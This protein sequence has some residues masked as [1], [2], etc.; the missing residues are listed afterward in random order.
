MEIMIYIF[1]LVAAALGFEAGRVAWA[2]RSAMRRVEARRR[3]RELAGRLESAESA[4]E[5][6]LLR[7][8]GPKLSFAEQ[9]FAG[10]PGRA[11]LQLLLYRAGLTIPV[12]RFVLISLALGVG[13][14]FFGFGLLGDVRIAAIMVLSG[15]LP[16][17]HASRLAGKRRLAF[18]Q[19][20]PD[21]LDLLI[22]A[23]RAGHSLSSGFAMV[24]KEMP[25][26]TSAEFTQ[27]ADEIR[28]GKAT[29][30]ALANMV[31]RVDSLDLPFFVTA[32]MI[33]QET[34][35]NLAEV[36]ENLG[37]VMRD[38]FK[39]LGKV[40][41]LTAMGRASAGVLVAWPFVTVALLYLT[42]PTYIE[43][44][45]LEPEGHTLVF[46]SLVMIAVGYLLCRKFAT[47]RV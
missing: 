31:H 1:V 42:N 25:N 26:P 46:T 11:P 27:L 5:E 41:A 9:L 29:R 43:P 35:S 20:F 15:L 39:V 16:W 4:D 22:R 8:G 32:V 3:L 2:G 24:G 19:Q 21:S 6:S 12:E 37:S 36:L 34:G 23:L 33:Q 14:G 18:E 45:W 28:M 13:G 10:L 7:S 40:R 47:I 17:A 38:R 44:L 30:L